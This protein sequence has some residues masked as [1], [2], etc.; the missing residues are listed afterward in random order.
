MEGKLPTKPANR[1]EMDTFYRIVASLDSLLKG[2]EDLKARHLLATATLRNLKATNMLPEELMVIDDETLALF[3]Y[4]NTELNFYFDKAAAG[5]LT[6]DGFLDIACNLLEAAFF[7]FL[8]FVA[9]CT[10]GTGAEKVL[11]VIMGLVAVASV[12]EAVDVFLNEVFP[13]GVKETRL[14]RTIK[15]TV[16]EVKHFAAELL[17]KLTGNGEPPDNLP[18]PAHEDE[19]NEDEDET[20]TDDEDEE[21]SEAEVENEDER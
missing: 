8:T 6:F 7:G 2:E 10:P 4:A 15:A 3:A 17:K 18:A 11:G 13:A 19:V 20:E 14:G 5:K 21:E 16:D 12:C 9:L 1:L